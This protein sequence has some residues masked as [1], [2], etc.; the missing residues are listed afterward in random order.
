MSRRMALSRALLLAGVIGL[1]AAVAIGGP[2][3]I[4][5]LVGSENATLDGQVPLPHTTLL[6]GDNLQVRDGLAMVTLDRGNRIILGRGTDASFTREADDVTVLL[7]RGNISLYH[8]A[9]GAAFR[10][11][12][13]DITVRPAPGRRALGEIAMTDG[14]LVVIA[15]DGALQVEKAGTTTEVSKGGTTT[16]ATAAARAPGP[17]PS[18]KPHLRHIVVQ[19]SLDLLEVVGAGAGIALATTALTRSRK[20]V[21]P[22]TPLP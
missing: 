17:S 14:L 5:S 11:M 9:A 6:S 21:S 18:P 12:V 7:T 13:G 2:I 16:I 4:G 22:V 10:V 8:P 3:P 1:A 19:K 15:K 20:Q